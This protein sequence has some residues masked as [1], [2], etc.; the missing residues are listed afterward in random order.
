MAEPRLC[1]LTGKPSLVA[2]HSP[3]FNP[4][5]VDPPKVYG[6]E[7]IVTGERQRAQ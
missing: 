2:G 3:S 6:V 4:S 1:S 7:S 5:T